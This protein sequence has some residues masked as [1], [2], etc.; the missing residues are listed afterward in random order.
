MFIDAHYAE[1][2][3][4]DEIANEGY[5][6]KHHFIREFKKVYGKT[7]YNY[8]KSVRIDQAV[9]IN[10]SLS[11]SGAAQIQKFEMLQGKMTIVG[12]QREGE[13]VSSATKDAFLAAFEATGS[14]VNPQPPGADVVPPGSVAQKPGDELYLALGDS[15]A[16]NVGVNRAQDGYVSRF[17]AHLERET[18]RDLGLMNLGISGESSISIM[19]GQLP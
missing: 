18:G 12:L 8:L 5:Y 13:I 19:R 17:H 3:N 15:L 4:L 9:D 7:P 14:R 11:E 16:A 1:E 10:R 2:I 6:S